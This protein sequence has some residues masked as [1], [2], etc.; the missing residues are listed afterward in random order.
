MKCGS[1]D[2]CPECPINPDSLEM[3]ESDWP[4]EEMGAM[5]HFFSSRPEALDGEVAK[6]LANRGLG[7]YEVRVNSIRTAAQRIALSEC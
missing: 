5:A 4:L 2:R 6:A 3:I 1:L 7:A